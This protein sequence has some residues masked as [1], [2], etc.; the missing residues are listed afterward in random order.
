MALPLAPK[1]DVC[2][3]LPEEMA[4]VLLQSQEDRL[5]D[6]VEESMSKPNPFAIL[7]QL[8]RDK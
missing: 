1:H 2:P 6:G 7:G 5:E 3:D 8:R 4:R